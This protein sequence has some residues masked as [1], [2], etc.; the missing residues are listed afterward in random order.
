MYFSCSDLIETI[1]LYLFRVN[2]AM[3]TRVVHSKMKKHFIKHFVI[4]MFLKGA[5]IR[6]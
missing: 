6:K 5:S 3:D 2:T 1:R 4:I